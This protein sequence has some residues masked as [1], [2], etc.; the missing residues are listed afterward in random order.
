MVRRIVRGYDFAADVDRKRID[1]LGA[2]ASKFSEWRPAREVLSKVRAVRTIFPQINHGTRVGGWPVQRVALVHGPSNHGKTILAHGLGLSFLRSGHYY[3]YI[4]AEF[5]TP[6]TW[7]DELMGE[8]ADY[9]TF[10]ALYP[11]SYEDTVD[12]VRRFVIAIIDAK[13]A[14]NAPDDTTGLIV[15]DSLRK[16]VPKRQLDHLSKKEGG[17]DGMSGRMAMYK[18]ALNSAWLDE[19]VPLMFHGQ[20]AMLF[21]GREADNVDSGMFGEKWRLTGGKGVIFDSSLLIRVTRAS[22]VTKGDEVVGERHCASI[23]KTKIGGK[24]GKS[25]DCYFHTSNGVFVPTGFDVARDAVDLGSSTG[26]IA[27]SGAWLCWRDQRWNGVHNAV[28][29]LQEDP[30]LLSELIEEME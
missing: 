30:E 17:V 28:K 24:Q 11:T 10:R 2:I 12:A 7:V 16:L 8:I 29:A 19:L 15:V 18:A 13:Q 26:V 20:M 3:C 14:G 6:E 5:A 25:T 23:W 1:Q 4:D 9:P 22:W 21:I 27:K